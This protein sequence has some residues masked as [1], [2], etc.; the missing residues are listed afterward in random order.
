MSLTVTIDL[1]DEVASRFV[2]LLPEKE[3]S[4][5]SVD[6]IAEALQLRQEEADDCVTVVEQALA[7]MDAG[8]GLVSFEEVCR[9]WDAEKAARKTAGG[10]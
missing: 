7:D 10:Q 2:A 5:F 3:R 4:Q 6:A 8:I 1:P 9:Q